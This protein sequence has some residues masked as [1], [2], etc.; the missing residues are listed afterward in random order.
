MNLIEAIKSGKPFKRRCRVLWIIGHDCQNNDPK[1]GI[2]FW[3]KDN[4]LSGS[5][6]VAFFKEDLLADD[7]EIQEPTVTITYSQL[8]QAAKE[9]FFQDKNPWEIFE[10]L[11]NK[12]GLG[13]PK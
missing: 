12:L 11:A 1:D 9:V 2:V 3:T 7:Y 10:E 13:D 4:D 5:N 8:R 6:R